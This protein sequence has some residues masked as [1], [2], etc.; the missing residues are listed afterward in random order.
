[1]PIYEYVC[2]DCTSEFELLVLGREK[3]ACPTCRSDKL[4]KLLSVPA[5]PSMGRSELPVCERPTSGGCGLPQC[6]PGGCG[7]G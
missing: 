7:M 6:G 2:S 1:M 4:E 5:A 3:P